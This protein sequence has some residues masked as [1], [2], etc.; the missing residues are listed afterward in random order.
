MWGIASGLA[1]LG[2]GLILIKIRR[3]K[4]ELKYEC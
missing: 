4:E 1:A 3:P 2:L